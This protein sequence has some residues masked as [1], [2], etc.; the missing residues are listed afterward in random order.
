M[1][2]YISILIATLIT[3]PAYADGIRF[4]INGKNVQTGEYCDGWSG[5][6]VGPINGYRAF[7]LIRRTSPH[8]MYAVR[9]MDNGDAF[10]VLKHLNNIY[11]CRVSANATGASCFPYKH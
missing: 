10:Y 2:K 7:D 11:H 9:I 5:A 8:Q 6:P 1:K 4:C 3:T